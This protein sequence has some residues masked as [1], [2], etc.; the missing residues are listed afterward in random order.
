MTQSSV[1]LNRAGEGVGVT[2]KFLS[3]S[4]NEWAGVVVAGGGHRG[5]SRLS[6]WAIG[7]FR[8]GDCW[9]GRG[10]RHVLPLPGMFSGSAGSSGQ[11][12]NAPCSSEDL[13]Q[14]L[15]QECGD[16][17]DLEDVPMEDWPTQVLAEFIQRKRPK[18]G[19]DCVAMLQAS[20]AIP[21]DE[22]VTESEV[23]EKAELVKV[24]IREAD[25]KFGEKVQSALRLRERFLECWYNK[26]W[27]KFKGLLSDFSKI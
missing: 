16:D 23:Q 24:K 20:L 12:T 8:W 9:R 7:N 27:D 22:N 18:V 14:A 25:D 21:P 4:L 10:S 17:D 1:G 6:Q 5:F 2:P 15:T 11:L 26:D 13:S 3:D 19:H